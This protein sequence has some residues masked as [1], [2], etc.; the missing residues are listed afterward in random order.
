MK[1]TMGNIKSQLMKVNKSRIL[2]GWVSLMIFF[3]LLQKK[4]D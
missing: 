2:L 1:E 3:L 4:L